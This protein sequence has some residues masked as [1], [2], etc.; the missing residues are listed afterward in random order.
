[1]PGKN[2]HKEPFDEGTITKLDIFQRYAREWL[3]VFV[4]AQRRKVNIFDFFAGTGYDVKGMPG[5]PIRILEEIKGQIENIKKNGTVIHIYLNE[6]DKKKQAQ[7]IE[8]VKKYLDENPELKLPQNIRIH[9]FSDDF[10][11]LYDKLEPLIGQ[12]PSL[13]YLDQNGIKFIADK[14]FNSLINKPQTD[15]FYYLSSSFFVR[16]GDTPEFKAIVPQATMEEIREKPYKYIHNEIL[17]YLK[18]KLPAGSEVMLYPF[19]I[20]KK[21]GVYGIIFGASHVLAA[22]KFL[23][24]AWKI[25]EVNGAANF[26][27]D[28]DWEKDQL[29]FDF[30]GPPEIKKV[31]AFKRELRTKILAGE[32]T[33][34]KEA[35]IFTIEKGHIGTHAKEEV[36]KMKKEK[37]ITYEGSWPK[38]N[39]AAA[40]KD[41]EIVEYKIIKK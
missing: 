23:T 7:L 5:S 1:M 26:D 9:P 27:I 19:T 21:A 24:I 25:N 33:N 39:Y 18:K 11:V 4:M 14:Y 34:N 31:D 12:E 41:N 8:A 30:W 29:T 28:D 37:L 2:I 35:Y 15:F 6:Y 20:K 32:I 3:P 40:I 13:V 10:E 38:V 17:N 36:S 16:F 22:D